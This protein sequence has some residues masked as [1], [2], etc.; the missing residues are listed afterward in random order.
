MKIAMKRQIAAACGLNNWGWLCTQAQ[1]LAVL[2]DKTSTPD[3]VMDLAEIMIAD[4]A[5]TE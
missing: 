5:N 1:F 4:R 2:N 3:R